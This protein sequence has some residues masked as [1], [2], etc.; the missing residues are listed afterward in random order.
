[1][2]VCEGIARQSDIQEVAEELNNKV[3]RDDV[4][5]LV[6]QA[7]ENIQVPPNSRDSK[8]AGRALKFRWEPQT[9]E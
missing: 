6:T 4:I 3:T 1:M 9:T 5:K 7:M 8:Y 2:C